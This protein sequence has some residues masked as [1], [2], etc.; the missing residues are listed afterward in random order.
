MATVLLTDIT[1]TQFKVLVNFKQPH[2]PTHLGVLRERGR[3][4]GRYRLM[5]A[6]K[7]TCAAM[8]HWLLGA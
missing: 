8:L 6:L 3:E 1:R 5:G 2:G 4:K 7:I